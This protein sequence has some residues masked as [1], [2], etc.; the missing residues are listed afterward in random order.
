MNGFL[1]KKINHRIKNWLAPVKYAEMQSKNV[2]WN[3]Y[4]NLYA[5]A[6]NNPV[7]Y[8]DPDGRKVTSDDSST[9]DMILEDIR[10]SSGNGFYF[11]E[12]NT[13]QIDESVDP[14]ENYSEELRNDLISL[15]NGEYKDVQ[16]ALHYSAEYHIYESGG[17]GI[18]PNTGRSLY[19]DKDGKTYRVAIPSHVTSESGERTSIFIHEFKGH[20]MSTITGKS[21]TGNA[22]KDTMP[23]INSLGLKIPSGLIMYWVED[24]FL[25]EIHDGPLTSVEIDGWISK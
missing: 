25:I 10:I 17:D 23:I 22:V 1:N 24:D 18:V 5:Y 3:Q 6:A 21:P 12:N 8:I 14:G 11:D 9:N 20:T 15:I 7:H 16:V 4:T 13:L 19:G 2:V